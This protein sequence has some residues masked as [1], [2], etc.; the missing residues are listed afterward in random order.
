MLANPHGSH[1]C[2]KRRCDSAGDR[3]LYNLVSNSSQP[4]HLVCDLS[5]R[6]LAAS[7]PRLREWHASAGEWRGVS[8]WRFAS[9]EIRAAEGRLSALGWYDAV[10][11]SVRFWTGANHSPVVTIQPGLMQ[12]D[13][14]Q[15]S[16]GTL[17][18]LVTSHRGSASPSAS[19]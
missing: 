7:R 8:L 13:R 9:A 2:W 12:W 4:V 11:P 10:A 14:L 16:D 3:A 6:L 1:A 5:H 19:A 17:A 15:L 18:R